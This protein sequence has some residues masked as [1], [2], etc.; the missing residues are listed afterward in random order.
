[1][2]ETESYSALQL[3]SL[4]MTKIYGG[5]FIFR[6]FRKNQCVHRDVLYMGFKTQL[7]ADITTK[8]SRLQLK[9]EN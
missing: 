9:T 5:L 8:F 1:M 2:F 3:A 7:S 6:T 4:H